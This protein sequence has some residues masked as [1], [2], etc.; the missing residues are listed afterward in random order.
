MKRFHEHD[1]SHVAKRQKIYVIPAVN[2]EELNEFLSTNDF[3]NEAEKKPKKRNQKY[4]SDS[5][6]S[7]QLKL[8]LT[9]NYEKELRSIR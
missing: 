3:E 2:E 7:K 4:N 9:P 6:D 1:K 5:D 8:K